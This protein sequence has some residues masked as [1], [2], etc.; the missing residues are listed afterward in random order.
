MAGGHRVDGTCRSHQFPPFHVFRTLLSSC[1]GLDLFS[2][3]YLL[4]G[5]RSRMLVNSLPYLII[6]DNTPTRLLPED[7]ER[8][9]LLAARYSALCQFPSIDLCLSQPLA[10]PFLL[11]SERKGH[12]YAACGR[13]IPSHSASSR[14]LAGEWLAIVANRTLR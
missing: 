9:P 13:S 3:C 5:S 14:N 8:H 1:I 10:L 6:P 4:T 11:L 12:S 2:F 7:Q